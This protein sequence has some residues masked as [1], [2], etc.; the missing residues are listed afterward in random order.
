MIL[1]AVAFGSFFLCDV[2]FFVFSG[3]SVNPYTFW[4]DNPSYLA[5]D[6]WT[7]LG[8]LALVAFQAV[9]VGFQFCPSEFGEFLLS[10]PCMMF[11]C[12]PVRVVVSVVFF[13]QGLFF[14][15]CGSGSGLFVFLAAAVWT[16]GSI[17]AYVALLVSTSPVLCGRAYWPYSLNR[18]I[19]CTPISICAC[20]AVFEIGNVVMAFFGALGWFTDTCATARALTALPLPPLPGSDPVGSA[21]PSCPVAG[22]PAG[23]V[24]VFIIFSIAAGVLAIVFNDIAWA[25]TTAWIF[26]GSFRIHFFRASTPWLFPASACS[27]IVA[28]VT[29][30]GCISTIVCGCVGFVVACCRWQ[31]HI[32]VYGIDVME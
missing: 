31:S 11:C 18:L 9:F 25:C 27:D 13:A 1:V 10:R 23:A 8:F 14:I 29:M 15:A 28:I 32:S 26:F 12:L 24:V 20:W 17:S 3:G 7:G 16:W 5:V 6:E 22:S 4:S 19:Y 30:L 21:L 2:I